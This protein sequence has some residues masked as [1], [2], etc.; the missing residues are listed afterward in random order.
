MAGQLTA[1]SFLSFN[2]GS[3]LWTKY[4][5]ATKYNATGKV[6]LKCTFLVISGKG[7]F[8]GAK[9]DGTCEGEQTRSASVGGAAPD[10]IGALDAV[11]NIKK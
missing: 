4:N 7:R 8:D 9:G 2:D 3:E 5:G 6:L 10:A 1:I 11:F